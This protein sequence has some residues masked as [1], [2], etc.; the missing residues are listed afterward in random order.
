MGA[1]IRSA[2]AFGVARIVL[3]KEAA[4]PYHHAS[5]RTAGSAVWRTRILEGPSISELKV[6]GVPLVTL[7][8]QGKDLG[9]YRFPQSFGL[10]PGL[11][12]PGLPHVLRRAE[13]LSIP[14]SPGVESLNAALA[15]GIALYAW[16]E[17]E[18]RSGPPYP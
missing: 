9:A 14:M 13:C 18:K 5:L 8:P 3:L 17:Q 11:E 10:V 7:S 1:V 4:H 6:T 16:R 15:T 2:A 12:G